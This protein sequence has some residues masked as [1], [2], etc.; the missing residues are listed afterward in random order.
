M[1]AIVDE[2]GATA[3]TAAAPVVALGRDGNGH[4]YVAGKRELVMMDG[5]ANVGRR[6]ENRQEVCVDGDAADSLEGCHRVH[7]TLAAGAHHNQTTR[8]HRYQT[9]SRAPRQP[10]VAPLLC[11]S[12]LRI[13]L[14]ICL[15]KVCCCSSQIN[16]FFR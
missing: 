3:G 14:D 15:E 9:R 16:S 13:H 11:V 4:A 6:V 1:A 12:R 8:E 2:E 5:L 10:P 7:R